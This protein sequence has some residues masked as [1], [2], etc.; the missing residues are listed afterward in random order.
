[1]ARPFN[2]PN[3]DGRTF[4]PAAKRDIMGGIIRGTGPVDWFGISEWGRR[5]P[6]PAYVLAIVLAVA[7]IGGRL[8]LGPALRGFP[9]LTFFPAIMI[10]T[11]VG[12]RRVGSACA[13]LSILLAWYWLIDP[14]GSFALEWPGGVIALALFIAVAALV[15]TLIDG[16]VRARF[17]ARAHL[18]AYERLNAEL[19]Q[20]VIERTSELTREIAVRQAAEEQVRQL[21]R[22]EVVGQLTGGIAHDFNNML[23]IVMGN[24]SLASRKVALGDTDVTRYIDRANEGAARAAALTRRLLAFARRQPLE[25]AVV[26]VNKLVAGM[27]E[28]LERTL[29]ELVQIETVLAG[30]AWSIEIDRGQLE[31]A[32]LNLAVNARDAMPTGGKLT[33]EVQNAFLDEDYADAEPDLGPGQYVLVAVSDTGEGMPPEVVAH[34]FEPF[35]TTKDKARGTGLGLSQ[36]Y[37]FVKQSGGH[38]RIYSEVGDGT[39]VKLYLRRYTGDLAPAIETRRSDATP[40]GSAGETILVVEDDA[41]V[42]AASVE[43]LQTLGYSVL[44]AED[45]PSALA[46]LNAAADVTLLFTDVVM[47]GMSGRELA[48]AA[49]A[50]RP[51]L[52]TLYTT[53]YTR[54]SIVHGGRLDPGVDLIQKPFT[55]DQLARKVRAVLDR[56]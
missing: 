2:V 42:R 38:I 21:Q 3:A 9:F 53:G 6:I 54:N 48:E 34:A 44:E 10:A 51:D 25:P 24:L 11:F 32:I 18:H 37:G 14:P 12:G 45:G 35:F 27:S 30:G 43:T 15:V 31:N 7:G 55:I 28:L 5:H 33:I 17:R 41:S 4:P 13:G 20:R 56:G 36:V 16:L 40:L 22:L 47:P 49:H 46:V 23:S 50:L 19:E 26:N 39:T 8:A 1:M 52:P 29:G